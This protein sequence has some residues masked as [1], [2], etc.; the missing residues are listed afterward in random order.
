[1]THKSPGCKE[2]R[3]RFHVV[4]NEPSHDRVSHNAAIFIQP[5]KLEQAEVRAQMMDYDHVS[6]VQSVPEKSTD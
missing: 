2:A 3:E 4:L 6:M 1:M 5:Q